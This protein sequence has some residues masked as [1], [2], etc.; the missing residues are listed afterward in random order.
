MSEAD[1][2]QE[3][4]ARLYPDAPDKPRG[5]F[6][7]H[8]IEKLDESG[9]Q[10]VLNRLEAAYNE[11]LSDIEASIRNHLRLGEGVHHE[12][13]KHAC[14]VILGSIALRKSGAVRS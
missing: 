13:F 14:F 5:Q 8:V 3:N 11:A 10:L 6:A 9:R 1:L 7:T 2:D 4:E 12:Q